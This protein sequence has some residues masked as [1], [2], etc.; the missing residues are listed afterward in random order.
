MTESGN[1]VATEFPGVELKDSHKTGD[2]DDRRGKVKIVFSY[3]EKVDWQSGKMEGQQLWT[4]E[5]Y[6][7]DDNDI[8]ASVIIPVTFTRV[9]NEYTTAYNEAKVKLP[10]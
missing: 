10:A 8:K 7:N 3:W 6:S 2:D 5:C 4:L 9:C 1:D